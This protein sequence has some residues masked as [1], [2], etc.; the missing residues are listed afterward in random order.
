MKFIHDKSNIEGD[1]ELAD[2][3]SV[4]P[5]ASI[6]GDEGKI[7]IGENTSVQDNVTIHGAATI[8][9]NVTIGHNAVI[10]GAT[11]KDNVI[12]GMNSTILDGAEIGEWS[13]I[14]A[15]A[16]ITPNKKIEPESVVMGVPG[17]VV[18][19]AEDKDRACITKSYQNYLDKIKDKN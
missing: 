19:K 8:G 17:K 7:I 10:H 2:G 12:V 3:V 14:A 11:I 13:I 16:V 9:K 1:V 4:W 6:R 18:R 5:F 15:G